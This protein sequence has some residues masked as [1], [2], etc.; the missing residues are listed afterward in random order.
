MPSKAYVF[1]IGIMLARATDAVRICVRDIST[2][3]IPGYLTCIGWQG[4]MRDLNKLL[5]KLDE[6]VDRADLDL[7][8][9]VRFCPR[10]GLSITFTNFLI[11]NLDGSW[12]LMILL[13]MVYAFQKNVMH[14]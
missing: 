7:N 6:F 3:Q 9:G 13:R 14:C 4:A 12:F 5:L 1:Q 10:L 8:V 11:L 2:D